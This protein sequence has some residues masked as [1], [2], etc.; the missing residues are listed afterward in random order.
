MPMTLE[1]T[2]LEKLS[3]W[4]PPPARA[5]LH[6]AS[7]GWHAMVI[8]DRS[9]AL[10]CLLW[11]LKLQSDGTDEID[12]RKWADATAKRVSGLTQPLKVVEVDAIRK[13]AQLRSDTVLERGDK[14]LYHELLLNGL[15]HAVLRRFQTVNGTTGREQVT[16]AVTHEAVARLAEDVKTA[17]TSS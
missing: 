15:G 12:V 2:L 13:E 3:E 7:A 1:S 5:E 11:E 14:R 9:D 6:V 17:A 10:G 16:F 8:A 4:Q